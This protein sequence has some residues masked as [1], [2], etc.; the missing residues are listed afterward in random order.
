MYFISID[1]FVEKINSRHNGQAS[2][3]VHNDTQ[4]TMHYLIDVKLTLVQCHQTSLQ[5]KYHIPFGAAWLL[6]VFQSRFRSKKFTLDVSQQCVWL[7]LAEFGVYRRQL[8]GKQ[9]QSA[10]FENQQLVLQLSE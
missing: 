1:D 6:K 5:L 10:H 2:V 9:I 8:G 3:T 7:H 4:I